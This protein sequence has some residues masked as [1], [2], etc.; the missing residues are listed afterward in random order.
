M[1]AAAL[2]SL[3]NSL[4]VNVDNTDSKTRVIIEPQAAQNPL[5]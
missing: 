4:D 5:E 2:A 3:A 1:T